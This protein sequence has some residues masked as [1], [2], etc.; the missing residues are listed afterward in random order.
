M[1]CWLAWWTEEIYRLF[2]PS[3]IFGEERFAMDGSTY[4]YPRDAQDMPTH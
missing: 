1:C 3:G 4:Y 2:L